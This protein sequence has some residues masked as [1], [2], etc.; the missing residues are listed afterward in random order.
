MGGQGRRDVP[1]L[2]GDKGAD[3]LLPITDQA[4]RHRLHPSRAEAPFD[5]VPEKR[6]DLVAHEAIEDPA[7][8][9]GLEFRAVEGEGVGDGVQNSLLGQIVK[10]GAVKL[11]F[12]TTDFFGYMPGDRLSFPIRVGGEKDSLCFLRSLFDLGNDLFLAFY[13][14]VAWGKV[15]FQIYPQGT[16]GQIFDVSQRCP[17]IKIRAK[18]FLDGLHLGWRFHYN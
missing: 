15:A 18:K 11:P 7:G 9:L 3:F 10:E 5:L 8:L 16:L 2:F 14:T 1:V 12:F 6:A 4:H 13:Y 17:H